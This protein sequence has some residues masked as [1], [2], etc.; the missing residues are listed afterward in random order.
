M[1]TDN[2]FSIIREERLTF[3]KETYQYVATDWI[4]LIVMIKKLQKIN[5]TKFKKNI[6]I[7]MISKAKPAQKKKINK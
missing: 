5:E 6:F 2:K 1:N 4:V 3:R 7:S